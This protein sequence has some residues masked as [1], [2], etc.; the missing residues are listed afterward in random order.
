MTDAAEPERLRQEIAESRQELGDTVEALAAKTDVKA[1]AKAKLDRTRSSVA[2]PVPLVTAGA[3]A[4]GLVLWRLGA[5]RRAE[6]RR[7][8]TL[9]ERARRRVAEVRRLR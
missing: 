3:V 8:A 7:R 6:Q 4:A 5:R 1:H 2:K 9:K